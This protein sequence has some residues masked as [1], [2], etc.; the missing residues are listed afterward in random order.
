MHTKTRELVTLGLLIA[1]NIILAR[2]IPPVYT[3]NIRL[4]FAFLTVLIAAALYGPLPAMAV[5]GLSD[6]LGAIL[7]P[8]GAYFPGFTI[9]EMLV[10]LIY[11]FFL[12]RTST[13]K[14]T[15]FRIA[16]SAFL[17]AL[18]HL[19]LTTYWLAVIAAGAGFLEVFTPWRLGEDLWQK[20]VSLL[21]MRAVKVA[22]SYLLTVI[23]G[24]LLLP[25]IVARVRDR[26]K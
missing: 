15:F 24:P 7:L 10:G 8:K 13:P 16:L 18:V 1:I 20:Y 25:R 2:V 26:Q 5:A 3:Q 4:D 11:G 9:S 22:V 6:F 14:E 23:I 17:A 21:P 19:F 12:Y